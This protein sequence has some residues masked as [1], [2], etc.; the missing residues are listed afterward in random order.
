MNG[1]KLFLD[2]NAFIYFFEGRSHITELVVQTPA[3]YFSSISEIELLSAPHLT[4]DEIAQIKAFLFLC[5]RVELTSEVI[6]QTIT[7]RRQ[8]RFKTPDAIIAASAL[9]LNIPLVSADTDFEKVAGLVL[10]SDI[11]A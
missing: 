8:Y 5:Q 6:E 4:P 2:T 1:D 7:I 11:L 9:N 3:I 10:I